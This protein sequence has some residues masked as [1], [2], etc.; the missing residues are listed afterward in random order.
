MKMAI[1]RGQATALSAAFSSPSVLIRAIR[2]ARFILS[3]RFVF[4]SIYL[5]QIQWAQK[6]QMHSAG[7]HEAVVEANDAAVAAVAAAASL[8][9]AATLAVT[10]KKAVAEAIYTAR[11]QRVLALKISA[12]RQRGNS[13]LVGVTRQPPS[14]AVGR[15]TPA[16]W[17]GWGDSDNEHPPTEYGGREHWA[18]A[19]AAG[20]SGGGGGG[21]GGGLSPAA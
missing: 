10:A 8:V 1:N 21:R 15:R 12:A 13:G 17:G 14:S 3:R 16:T 5:T 4:P 11:Y 7:V 19:T 6:N 2:N 18:P 9:V 20:A